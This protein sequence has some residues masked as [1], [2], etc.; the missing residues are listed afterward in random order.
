MHR[1][2]DTYT[3]ATSLLGKGVVVFLNATK[4]ELLAL[5]LVPVNPPEPTNVNNPLPA[6]IAELLPRFIAKF[7]VP[8]IR[9]GEGDD[10]FTDRM[11]AW[12][13]PLHEHIEFLAP[14]QGYGRKRADPGRPWGKDSIP[15]VTR[16]GSG[17]DGH[18]VEEGECWD[19]FNGT[20]TG[21]PSFNPNVRSVDLAGQYFETVAAVDRM[22]DGVHPP[23]PTVEAPAALPTLA[24]TIVAGLMAKF[25]GYAQGTAQQRRDLTYAC[26]Q[27][28]AHSLSPKFGAKKAAPD[29]DRSKNAVAFQGD[30]LYGYVLFSEDGTPITGAKRESMAGQVFEPVTPANIL[31]MGKPPDPPDPT[32]SKLE[33]RVKVLEDV[34]EAVRAALKPMAART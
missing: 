25:A 19:F 26:A 13:L 7:P 6:F 9:E 3:V 4:A 27:Q 5:P 34:L 12:M 8:E 17:W 32:D 1:D 31:N 21:H 15:H 14:G 24:D 2:G 28:L 30:P 29:R 33:A 10:A 23:D 11:R 22:G 18:S 20:G 16:L